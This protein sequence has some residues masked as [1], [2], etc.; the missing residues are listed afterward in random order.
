VKLYKGISEATMNV[1][2]DKKTAVVTVL[3][4]NVFRNDID[5]GLDFWPKQVAND[6]MLIDYVDSFDLLKSIKKMQSE[7]KTTNGKSIPIALSNLSKEITET[8][9]PVIIVLK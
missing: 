2:F 3:K 6:K 1:I 7:S 8:S 5:G 9:N 4:D